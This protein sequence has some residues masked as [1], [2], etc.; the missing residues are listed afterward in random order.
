MRFN[1]NNLNFKTMIIM[2]ENNNKTIQSAGNYKPLLR[3]AKRSSETIRQTSGSNWFRHWLAGVIDGDGNFDIQVKNNVERLSSLRIKL[4][5][6]DVKIL[7]VIQNKVH[8]GKIRRI[9]NKPYV[10]YVVSTKQDLNLIIRLV[11]G[12]IR[13]KVD[14]FKKACSCLNVSYVEA[15]YDIQPND[16]Y[17]A[18]LI[19]SDGSIVFNYAGNRIECN[20]E[21]QL[22]EVT[23]K[24]NLD[25]VIPHAQPSVYLRTKKN[26][27]KGKTFQS[28]AFKW[29]TVNGMIHVYNY[30]MTVRLFCDMKFYRVTRIKRFLEL[31]NYKNY[32]KQSVQFQAYAKLVCDFISYQNPK[33]Q[34]VGFVKNFFR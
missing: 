24:L 5:Q 11:N 14:G 19:D 27:T 25:K 29:Q 21:L 3:A 31:R 28:I 16:P 22:N 34:A 10:I 1:W 30:F 26:Q 23:K 9:K 17:F 32:Q 20:L 6:R 18:G 15:S 4:H 2:C 7:K 12:L 8:L 13:L 33:W